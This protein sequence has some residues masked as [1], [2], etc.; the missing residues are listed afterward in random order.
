[1]PVPK[2]AKHGDDH[3]DGGV[4]TE[5]HNDPKHGV[6]KRIKGME[7]NGFYN[8]NSRCQAAASEFG[9]P[10]WRE[11]ILQFLAHHNNQSFLQARLQTLHIAD[12]GS[13]QGRNSIPV[14]KAA[15]ETI[16]EHAVVAVTHLDLPTNDFNSLIQV[17]ADFKEGYAKSDRH[18]VYISARGRSFYEKSFP[19]A[20]VHLAWSAIAAHWLS[21]VP[22]APLN[23]FSVHRATN[24]ER[25][26]WVDQ[27]RK[28]WF[29]FV[30]FR[31][32][33]L[34][35]G[36]HFVQVGITRDADGSTGG[37]G[38]FDVLELTLKAALSKEQY[39]ALRS[40]VYTRSHEEWLEPFLA[41]PDVWTVKHVSYHTA[42][43]PF[44]AE[45]ETDHDLEKFIESACGIVRAAYFPGLFR[46]EDAYD[47]E[48]IY[49]RFRAH[50]R[51]NPF[52]YGALDWRLIVLD[53]ERR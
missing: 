42:I 2:G 24:T 22:A 50:F 1:M 4:A 21:E 10:V 12:Y 25:T 23:H 14:I 41:Q 51:S 6:S 31:S 11:A 35:S 49:D 34:I 43:N 3:H 40:P 8:K 13:S 7:G 47:I 37:E 39:G 26:Q 15:L 5:P 52:H 17:T 18:D 46:N 48:R 32:E 36:G 38:A 44:V 28:D 30:K 20:S 9:L 16:P 45:F 27:A 29:N 53:V 19:D 33:E